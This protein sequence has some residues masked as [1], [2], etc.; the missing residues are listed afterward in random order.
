[1]FTCN[2]LQ[3]RNNR[4]IEF[5]SLFLI[6]N[7]SNSECF[8]S[9]QTDAIGG[10]FDIRQRIGGAVGEVSVGKA[11]TSK[12]LKREAV[13]DVHLPGDAIPDVQSSGQEQH[14]PERV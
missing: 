2:L 10:K 7:L 3:P 13:L 8:N 1:M 12:E 4:S 14:R 6:G 5:I 11:A 9:F